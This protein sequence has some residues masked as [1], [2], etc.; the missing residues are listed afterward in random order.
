VS[1]RRAAGRI[2]PAAVESSGLGLKL[3]GHA[4]ESCGRHERIGS[5]RCSPDIHVVGRCHDRSVGPADPRCHPYRYGSAR[6]QHAI[7]S[8]RE[9]TRNNGQTTD[10]QK[11]EFAGPFKIRSRAIA[12]GN[13]R[14]S[15]PVTA[16][17]MIMR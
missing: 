9:P 7:E 12:S 3:S 5:L 4:A 17:P 14:T 15:S 13:Y 8:R 2:V 10:R 1:A 11:P 16:L 6:T